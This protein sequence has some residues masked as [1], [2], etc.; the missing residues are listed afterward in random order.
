MRRTFRSQVRKVRRVMLRQEAMTGS[1][2][3]GLPELAALSSHRPQAAIALLLAKALLLAVRLLSVCLLCVRIG[4]ERQHASDLSG[5]ATDGAAELRIAEC[6][7]D[8]GA[9]RTAEGA[10]GIAY[11]SLW[12]KLLLLLLRLLLLLL[13]LLLLRE[14]GQLCLLR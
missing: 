12:R 9:D 14:L 1:V 5:D 8:S 4:F 2:N 7:A 6:A 10:D 13:L 3:R 11:P